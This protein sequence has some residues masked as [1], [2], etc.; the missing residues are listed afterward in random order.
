[1][2]HRL[3]II[4]G[5]L[6]VFFGLYVLLMD[7]SPGNF[8]PKLNSMMGIV[9]IFYGVYRIVHTYYRRSLQAD[10]DSELETKKD[11]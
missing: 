2:N 10:V 11:E 1:M 7:P 6:F 9:W 8:H 5:Y 3:R 4:I